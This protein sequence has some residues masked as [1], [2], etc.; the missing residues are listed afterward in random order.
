LV[1]IRRHTVLIHLRFV[2]PDFPANTKWLSQEERDYA[3]A[4]LVDE[5][6]ATQGV[7]ERIGFL[8]AFKRAVSDWKM[9]LFTLAQVRPMVLN[10][11]V[12]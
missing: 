10:G 7:G 2:L 3:V 12:Q 5:A 11:I 9:W 4:R 1:Q 6:T 8:K